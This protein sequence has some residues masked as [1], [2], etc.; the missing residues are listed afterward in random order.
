ML[1]ATVATL[2]THCPNRNHSTPHI[3]LPHATVRALSRQRAA[4]PGAVGHRFLEPAT[5]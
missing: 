4:F 1:V 5:A 3:L 2:P